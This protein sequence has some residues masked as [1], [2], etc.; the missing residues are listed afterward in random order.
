M[1]LLFGRSISLQLRLTVAVVL[2]IILIIGD[3]YTSG[4]TFVRT[5]LNTLVSPVLYAA[6]VPYELFNVGAQSLHTRD[7]LLD[8]NET[9]RAKQLLQSEQLQQFQFLLKENNELRALLGASSRQSHSRQIAQVLSVRSN[10]YNHQVVINKGTIDGVS[11]GQAV[12]DEL[13][14]VGQLTHVGTT[15]SRVLLM[16][17]TTHATPVRIL[18]NDVSMVVEGIGKINLVQLAHVSHSLDIR[19]GDILV[20]S[21]LGS[22]FPEGY[23]VAVVTEIDRDEGLPFAKVYAEPIAQLDR[24]RLLVILGEND[25]E[26]SNE[27]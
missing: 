16:T 6:N 10:R 25:T 20:T 12:I 11:E 8:E 1:N 26:V 14:L 5:T 27:P 13:G 19:I 9:L 7:R 2:S 15:T 23:P 18:R 22:R 17:D 24:I 4:G 3:R 21:G